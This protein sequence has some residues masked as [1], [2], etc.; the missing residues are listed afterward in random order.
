MSAPD[1]ATINSDDIIDNFMRGHQF[2]VNEVGVEEPSISWQL[3][4]FGVSKGY[5][6]L[7]KDIG[8]EA[9]FFSRL[10]MIEKS[11]LF[12]EKKKIQMWRADEENFGEKKDILSVT[13]TQEQGNYCWPKGFAFD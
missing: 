8:F 3:D 12:N 6:R 7:A 1:E 2:L 13:I 11:K 5:A 9:I 10:D 4:S